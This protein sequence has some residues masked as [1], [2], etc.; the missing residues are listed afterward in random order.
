MDN[1]L[2]VS[3]GNC[4]FYKKNY[5]SYIAIKT[6]AFKDFF[7]KE[8]ETAKQEEFSQRT[9]LVQFFYSPI[10]VYLKL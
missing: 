5:N 10:L 4:V 9:Y 6:E 1:N 3:L 8:E 2:D 7:L